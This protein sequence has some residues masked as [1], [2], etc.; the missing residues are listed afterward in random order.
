MEGLS[1]SEETPSRD[2]RPRDLLENEKSQRLSH[3]FV[4]Q[5]KGRANL[6][7]C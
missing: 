4:Q 7:G 5:M 2:D 1:E 6:T 3:P